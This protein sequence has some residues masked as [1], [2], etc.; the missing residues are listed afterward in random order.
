MSLFLPL[1]NR[2]RRKIGITEFR[3]W[4]GTGNRDDAGYVCDYSPA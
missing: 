1:S 2:L 4:F 3:R